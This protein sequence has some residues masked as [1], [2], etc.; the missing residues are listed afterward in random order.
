MGIACSIALSVSFKGFN[1][2]SSIT[3]NHK[4]HTRYANKVD[5][6]FI[7]SV[8]DYKFFSGPMNSIVQQSQSQSCVVDTSLNLSAINADG[9]IAGGI[10]ATIFIAVLVTFIRF[11]D[12]E[13]LVAKELAD[14]SRLAELKELSRVKEERRIAQEKENE[15]KAAAL[16]LQKK[17]DE[18]RAA[19]AALKLEAE[20]AAALA[21]QKKLEEEKA[22]ALALQKLD[23]E[24]AAALALQ[25]QEEEK[26]AALALQKKLEGEKAAALALQKKLEEEKAA[27]LALQKKQEEEKAAALALQKKQEE[28][29]AAALALEKEVDEETVALLETKEEKP[30]ESVGPSGRTASFLDEMQ[31]AAETGTGEVWIELLNQLFITN[32]V[33]VLAGK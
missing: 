22:A 5:I 4:V 28:E 7:G 30:V 12:N 15:E 8:H 25:K 16:A 24:K 23:E 9:N 33:Y 27:A 29:K 32:F 11:K 13:E 2:R 26:A 1:A 14:K 6:G 20:K 21:L 31:S 18:E 3:Q 19:A 17:Q 10:V